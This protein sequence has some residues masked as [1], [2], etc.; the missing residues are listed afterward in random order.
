MRVHLIQ[1]GRAASKLAVFRGRT[2]LSLVTAPFRR[3]WFEYPI[4]AYVIEHGD[5]HIVVDTG[6]GHQMPS[7]PGFFRS[8]I[9][10]DDEIGPQM[11]KIGLR[12]EDVR[13]V[14]PTHL[15]VDH[16]GG[17]GHFPNADIVV[18]RPEYEYAST[19]RGRM[20]YQPR[21]WPD[22]FDPSPYD[23]EPE[24]FGPFPSSRAV[25]DRRDVKLVPIPGHSVAQV[26]VVVKTDGPFVFFAGDHMIRQDWFAEDLAAGRLSQSLHFNNPRVAAETSRRIQQFVREFPTV[27]VPAHDDDAVARLQSR[28][29]MHT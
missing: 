15:D 1:T 24:A 13:L 4:N 27:L 3:G 10:P 28:E 21:V 6:A 22:W 5:G 18:H 29:P 11:R 26:A 17:V 25:T 8:T 2:R 19:L 20:R 12:V 9:E 23:L 16:A 14:I 7:A